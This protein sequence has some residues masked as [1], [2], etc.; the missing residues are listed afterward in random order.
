MHQWTSEQ[1]ADIYLSVGTHTW[2]TD[3]YPCAEVA[4][5]FN[6]HGPFC[7]SPGEEQKEVAEEDIK[8]R[9]RL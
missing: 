5:T 8:V 6:R 3:T 9:R 7:K 4:F 1:A 2:L